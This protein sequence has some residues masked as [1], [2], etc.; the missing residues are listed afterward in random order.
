MLT[1]ELQKQMSLASGKAE[2]ARVL[3]DAPPL[4][5]EPAWSRPEPHRTRAGDGPGCSALAWWRSER[6]F[7][8]L[9][10]KGSVGVPAPSASWGGAVT[11]APLCGGARGR[12][13]EC[14]RTR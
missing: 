7:N 2:E 14:D 5:P 10:L 1:R 13:W 3:S 8:D 4:R 11:L 9:G 6:T 12:E